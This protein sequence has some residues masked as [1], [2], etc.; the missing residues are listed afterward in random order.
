MAIRCGTEV[1]ARSF[2]FNAAFACVLTLTST[3]SFAAANPER[4]DFQL[5]LAAFIEQ[6]RTAR[7]VP[8]GFVVVAVH[9]GDTVFE[10]AY[11]T[12]NLATGA[13]L[14]LDTPIYNASTT[15]AYTGL[16]AAI[17]D[18][19]GLL[20]LDATLREVWPDIPPSSTFDPGAIR[21]SALLAHIPGINEGGINFR[22]NVTGEISAAEIPGRL[23]AY[24]VK[25]ESGF[26]YSNFGPYVWSTMME[27]KLGVPWRDMIARE[28]FEPLE[29]RRT[30]ARL[31]DF[32][33][34]ELARCH[35]WMGGRW[36]TV[37]LKPTPILNAAGGIYTSGRD[38]GRFLKAFL[39]DGQS[40]QNRITAAALRRTWERVSVQDLDFFGLN[41]DGYGLG[42]DLGTYDGHRFVA[43]SGGANGC[44]SIILFLPAADFGMA[45]LSLGDDGAN[46]LNVS[47][48]KQAID[49]WNP[50]AQADER[51]RQR[52]AAFAALVV[53]DTADPKH[54]RRPLDAR[55]S[56]AAAGVYE[57]ERLGRFTLSAAGG[58]LTIS[59]GVFTAELVP[60]AEDEFLV[61]QRANAETETLRLIRGADGRVTGFMWD[62]DQYDRRAN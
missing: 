15:K 36:H 29:L 55:V 5:G 42:W 11:G 53:A 58:E 1:E 54:R 39:T 26:R 20:S 24:A 51:G 33:A 45:V 13:T 25:R 27:A 50:S 41:R 38:T 4:P 52:V 40:A 18:K 10:Q 59:G 9:G 22:S 60:V 32:P 3:S 12:R 34:G 44:R 7:Q 2:L 23:A 17:L 61:A 47:I 43:R 62:D 37:P 35:A 57:N 30:T 16:L 31:E 19:Q 46:S 48:V 8:P 56:E 28:L 21:A 49:L 14:T 6:L